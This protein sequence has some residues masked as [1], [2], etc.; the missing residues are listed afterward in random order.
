MVGCLM[1][2]SRSSWLITSNAG[3]KIGGTSSSNSSALRLGRPPLVPF[4]L[5]AIARAADLVSPPNFPS[6]FAALVDFFIKISR[7]TC[8]LGIITQAL[9]IKHVDSLALDGTS[10][11]HIL[12]PS[13]K[14]FPGSVQ[15][16]Y[17]CLKVAG[18]LNMQVA[19]V[20]IR[21]AVGEIYLLVERYDRKFDG[22]NIL[23]LHQED[24][25]QALGF[26]EKYQK[27]GGPGLANCFGLLMNTSVPIID[28]TRLMEGVI[29][30]YLIGNADAH[31]KNFSILYNKDGSKKLAPFYDILC[32]QVYED[33]NRDLCMKVG[34]HY[35][36][37]EVD[38]ADWERLCKD[39]GFSFS[40]AKKMIVDQADKLSTAVAEERQA[41]KDSGFDHSIL[42]EIVAHVQ[43]MCRKLQRGP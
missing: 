4:S 29:F 6:N 31:G 40:Q 23:R 35:N 34:K 1:I 36:F 26:R 24:F 11:T 20:E 37:A 22:H 19:N 27:W 2:P 18:R 21:Q 41:I 28:R 25:C 8:L 42:D 16:E 10:T 12:K 5:L 9:G 33:H 7:N 15:N 39:T 30:N 17:L 13:I 14:R 38:S 43:K 3:P 32:T